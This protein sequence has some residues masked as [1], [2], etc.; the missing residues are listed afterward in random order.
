[1]QLFHQ[2]YP[3]SAP[4][5]TPLIIIPGLFGST[6]NWRS[7]AKSLSEQ[8]EVS[9]IDQR[10]HGQSPHA[11]SQSY[12]DMAD[13]LLRFMDFQGIHDAIICG[14]SMGGKCAMVFSLLY[15]ERVQKLIV[16]DIAPVAYSHSHAPFLQA[17]TKIDLAHLQSRR[18]ADRALQPVIQDNAT[19]LFLLQ[20]LV[21]RPG[22]YQWRINLQVLHDEMP[23]LVGFPAQQ[24]AERGVP[25]PSKLPSA[26]IYGAESDYLTDQYRSTVERYFA[27][28]SYQA[29]D[30]AGHWLHAEQPAAVIQAIL[31]FS[32]K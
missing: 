7:V 32:R 30:K 2:H 3:S 28:P 19:R 12:F 8:H 24:L 5:A 4:Q 13:D 21:G 25:L 22:A 27:Q 6:S 26:F 20:N 29:I 14:H 23:L 15:P 18:E 31:D 11:D 16:L 9:V 1:M 10:N 17:L